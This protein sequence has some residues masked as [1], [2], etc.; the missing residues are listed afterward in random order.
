MINPPG[1]NF[2]D[3]DTEG[4]AGAAI[5]IPNKFTILDHDR[6]GD[7]IFVW[8]TINTS[9]GKF[10]IGFVYALFMHRM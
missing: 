1:T 9:E 10:R 5:V 8:V 2:A 3:Y 6:K 7:R 4:K